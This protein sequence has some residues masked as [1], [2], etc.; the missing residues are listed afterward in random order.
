MQRYS[1]QDPA[2]GDCRIGSSR[3]RLKDVGCLITAL[4][5]VHSKFYPKNPITPDTAAKTWNFVGIPGDK[6]MKY[7]DWANTDFYG[8]EF[9]H[10]SWDYIPERDNKQLKNWMKSKEYGVV[11]QVLTRGGGQHWVAGV[12]KSIFG[13]AAND[14]WDGKRL[15]SLPKPYPRITG[16]ALLKRKD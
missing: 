10:R 1:Q 12:G 2:W 15:W 7:L 8:M 5:M 4:C 14:P 11:F 13:W 16:W 6:T 9:I 3:S